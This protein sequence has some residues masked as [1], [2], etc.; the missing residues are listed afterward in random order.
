MR[1]HGMSGFPLNGLCILATVLA[2]A[3]HAEPPEAAEPARVQGPRITLSA[4]EVDFGP[5]RPNETPKAAVQVTNTGDEPLRITKVTSTC[6]CTKAEL[7]AETIRPG[8]S[9]T[10]EISLHLK[11]YP[12]NKVEGKVYIASND[13]ENGAAEIAVRA[14]VLPEYV[15]APQEL[16]F[17]EVKAETAAKRTL[18]I[19]QTGDEELVLERVDS[20]PELACS[21]AEL[22]ADENGPG[23]KTYEV[24]VELR[25]QTRRGKFNGILALATNI[26]RAPILDV[27]VQAEVVGIR[28][29]LEPKVVVFGP[30]PPGAEVG[31]ITVR[32]DMTS[33]NAGPR[34]QEAG[35][36]APASQANVQGDNRQMPDC[37][38]GDSPIQ[39]VEAS[40]SVG[41]IQAEVGGD[42]LSVRLRVKGDATSGRKVGEVC[43]LLQEG[44]LQE[45][46]RVPLYGSVGV[47]GD[48]GRV[49]KRRGSMGYVDI[50]IQ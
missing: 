43:I 50:S 4:S 21:F 40:C 48:S 15:V 42:G 1:N 23:R 35:M 6:S 39:V 5:A 44:K 46:H 12:S 24:V 25:P 18:R 41:D 17:G 20:P 10:L 14:S 38:V 32:R 30:V 28:C 47:A 13:S 19:T 34:G 9:A 36:V 31:S 7:A 33:E 29:A 37:S 26:A 16:D 3:C 8:Q 11:E 2:G 49:M 27:R 22:P 45:T